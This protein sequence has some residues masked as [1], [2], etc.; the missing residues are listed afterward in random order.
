MGFIKDGMYGLLLPNGKYAEPVYDDYIP[1]NMA[2]DGCV[3][4]RKDEE[5]GVFA[6]PDYEYRRVTREKSPFACQEDE[7]WDD[8]EE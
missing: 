6:W 5:Y 4:V 2:E 7:S 8:S 1:D 3:W